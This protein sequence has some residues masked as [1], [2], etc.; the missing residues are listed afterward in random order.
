MAAYLEQGLLFFSF[1]GLPN[2]CQRLDG[3]PSLSVR[4]GLRYGSTMMGYWCNK[5]EQMK[6][7][8]AA[9]DALAP[10]VKECNKKQTQF[11]SEFCA[12]AIVY[13]G[14]CIDTSCE[15]LCF[16]PEM[17]WLCLGLCIRPSLFEALVKHGIS[18]SQYWHTKRIRSV[19][20][21]KLSAF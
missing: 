14:S 20:Q 6:A 13:P 8:A 9:T 15:I 2:V 16:L 17:K 18:R 5:D 10:V 3:T 7:C 11:E 21:W 4:S 12:M 1:F 19:L